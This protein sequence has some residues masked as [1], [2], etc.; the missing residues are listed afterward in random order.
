MSYQVL[1]Q[2]LLPQV[3]HLHMYE[4]LLHQPAAFHAN[5]EQQALTACADTSD[6]VT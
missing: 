4:V 2:Q 3:K 1:I 6:A 5:P